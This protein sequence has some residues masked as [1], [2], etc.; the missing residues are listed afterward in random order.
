M[1]TLSTILSFKNTSYLSFISLSTYALILDCCRKQ[2]GLIQETEQW[3]VTARAALSITMVLTSTELETAKEEITEERNLKLESLL[4]LRESTSNFL[5]QCL[6]DREIQKI[7]HQNETSSKAY[8]YNC[9][10][11]HAPHAWSHVRN[12]SWFL[13]R[14]S[15]SSFSWFSSQFNAVSGHGWN[16][17][18]SQPYDPKLKIGRVLA[19]QYSRHE[20]TDGN[21]SQ[22]A[23]QIHQLE[24]T[25]RILKEENSKVKQLYMEVKQLYM[26]R[27]KVVNVN[28]NA[29]ATA[30]QLSSLQEEI[31]QMKSIIESRT[32]TI[33]QMSNENAN[34][35][36]ELSSAQTTL[37]G[38]RNSQPSPRY[39][40]PRY[41]AD[42]STSDDSTQGCCIIM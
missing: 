34:L 26:D 20:Q 8:R 9:A 2:L 42:R 39:P 31:R 11:I 13:E 10:V 35:R 25:I 38:Y 7:I 23:I 4:Q 32:Q 5:I 6:A 21:N 19:K 27:L 41:T 14:W 28:N 24:D 18:T 16:S 30:K 15:L 1:A 36:V 17:N 33:R 3:I 29:N 12:L 22:Q 37:L 40:P